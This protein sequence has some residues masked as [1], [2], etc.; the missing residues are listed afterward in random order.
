MVSV[1]SFADI[2]SLDCRYGTNYWE[3]NKGFYIDL[4]SNTI[5]SYK[6]NGHT[7]GNEELVQCSG[8]KKGVRCEGERF[9]LTIPNLSEI[10]EQS[11][12]DIG[13][14]LGALLGVGNK[15]VQVTFGTLDAEGLIFDS[16]KP[17]VCAID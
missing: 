13:D 17:V 1:T 14:A 6:D 15:S 3:T 8:A 11:S 4:R 7:R 5:F 2:R 9:V 10:N 12:R 16:K